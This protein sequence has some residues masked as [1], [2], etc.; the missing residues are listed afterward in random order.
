MEQETPRG[1]SMVVCILGMH[2]SGTSCLTG[3]LEERGLYLGD[4]VTEAKFNR[5]G[6]R[7]NNELRIINDDL[8]A[9]NGG[10]WDKPPQTLRWDDEL[11]R[12]RDAGLARYTGIDRWGFKDPRVL[13]TLPFWLESGVDFTFVGTFRHPRAV[14]R[15]LLG[16]PGL[17]PRTEPTALWAHYNRKLIEYADHYEVPSV[18]FDW[19]APRYMRAV[20]EI[21]RRFGLDAAPADTDRFFEE[22][23]RNDFL[24]DEDASSMSEEETNIYDALMRYAVEVGAH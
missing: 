15:S 7:E 13:L 2:R 11:R 10:A 1:A 9:F 21:A 5:K 17:A 8:L 4:V 6:N 23:L 20:D 14:A 3:S 16:R 19:P 12:R 24:K 22:A 18:C